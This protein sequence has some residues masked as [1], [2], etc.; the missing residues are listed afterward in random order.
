MTT[1]RPMKNDDQTLAAFADGELTGEQ[2]LEVLR[3][4]SNDPDTA[5]R[6][7]QHQQLRQAVARAMDDPSLTTPAVLR[8]QIAQLAATVQADPPADAAPPASD[9]RTPVLAVIGRWLP[10]AVAALFFI[11]ALTALSI[12]D[13]TGP[14]LITSANVI[15]ASMIDDFGARHFKCSRKI[16]PMAQTDLFPRD[17][18]ALPGELSDYF[19][20]PIDPDVLNLSSV[21]YE[22]DMAG[23]CIVPGKGAVHLIYTA[24]APDGQIDALSLWLR[25]VDADSG[26]EPNQLYTA[27]EPSK[28]FPMLVWRHGDMAYHLV[29][30]SYDAVQRAFDAISAYQ[31]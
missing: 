20:Q 17:L 15:N 4:M 29:G 10:A 11:G 18:A 22:F 8:D 3:Q 2:N 28:N 23:L 16:T 19:D 7:A 27:A 12:A 6:V 14:Q 30:D 24:Q 21:G 5:E 25:P 31:D 26:I 9:Q 1:D 13:R